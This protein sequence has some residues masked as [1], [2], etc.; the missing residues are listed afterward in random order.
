MV[1]KLTIPLIFSSQQAE[2][3]VATRFAFDIFRPPFVQSGNS[4][5]F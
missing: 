5:T 4:G 2:I 1:A 3:V